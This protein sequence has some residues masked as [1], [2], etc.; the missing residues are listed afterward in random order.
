MTKT[1]KKLTVEMYNEVI[2]EIFNNRKPFKDEDDIPRDIPVLPKE[3]YDRIVVANLIRC[4]A[5]PKSKLEVGTRYLGHCRN[6]NLA[7]WNGERF[8]IKRFKFG[9][10][11]S[12][13]V[14]HFEDG[15]GN[16]NDVFIPLF[17]V[18]K[19]E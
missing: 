19:P 17:I 14:Q 5:I 3:E 6:S 12:D 18:V 10:Y 9:R 15:G 7:T 13:T 4:G 11:E 2:E 8:E 16:D 1:F